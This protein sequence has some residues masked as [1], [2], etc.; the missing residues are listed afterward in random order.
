MI[1]TGYE[2]FDR[3]EPKP[4]DVWI[5][6]SGT[7]QGKSAILRNLAVGISERGEDSNPLHYWDTEAAAVIRNTHFE[8]LGAKRERFV[9]H[10]DPL[11]DGSV[12]NLAELLKS[13]RAVFIDSLQLFLL[14]HVIDEHALME[15]KS[16]AVRMGCLVV[17]SFQLSRNTTAVANS[18]NLTQG[19]L[20]AAFDYASAV[21][22]A[23]KLP[24]TSES[25]TIV[26]QACRAPGAVLGPDVKQ[27]FLCD[28]E[29]GRLEP[30]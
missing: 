20:P 25:Q 11:R 23:H 18:G 4:G 15:L 21:F 8:K 16:F 12:S 13:T 9:F 7:H 6:A 26:V 30:L 5:V 1:K 27:E 22:V 14:R 3:F 29:T 19:H 10:N 2:F 17:S 24:G 28:P